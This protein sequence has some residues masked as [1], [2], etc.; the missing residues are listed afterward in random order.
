MK[1]SCFNIKRKKN[2]PYYQFYSGYLKVLHW[3]KYEKRGSKISLV[4]M[5]M[6]CHVFNA[7]KISFYRRK[8]DD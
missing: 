3:P 4:D 8:E 5:V 2:I 1:N 6:N 7:K